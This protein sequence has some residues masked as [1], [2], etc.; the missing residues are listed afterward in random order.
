MAFIETALGQSQIANTTT[1]IYTATV[2]SI[3]KHI[4]ITNTTTSDAT[5]TVYVD[6]NGT[7]ATDAEA[8]LKGWT[9][10]AND[11]LT[12]NGFIPIEAG[13]TIKAIG[14]TNNAI[15][16]TIGGATL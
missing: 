13:A 12:W 9:V 5:I 6:T 8:I 4:T 1:T 11:F 15:T 10:P 16:I 14:G 3:V 2:K 7:N